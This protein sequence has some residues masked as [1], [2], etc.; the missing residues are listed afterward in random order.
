[1]DYTDILNTI[2]AKLS[3]IISLLDPLD[4]IPDLQQISSLILSVLCIL[5]ILFAIR[6]E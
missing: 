6:G 5:V 2:S 3:T 1:M 4:V